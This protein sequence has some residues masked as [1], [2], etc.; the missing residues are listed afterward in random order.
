MSIIIYKYFFFFFFYKLGEKME[1]CR[2]AV[3]MSEFK[4]SFFSSIDL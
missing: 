3:V 1:M 2:S 4:L